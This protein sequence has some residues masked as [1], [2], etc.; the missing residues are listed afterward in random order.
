MYTTILVLDD[1][2]P[3]LFVVS[4][5]SLSIIWHL[6]MNCC[7]AKSSVT[8]GKQVIGLEKK[9]RDRSLTGGRKALCL[10]SDNRSE[11]KIVVKMMFFLVLMLLSL[12][13]L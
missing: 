2:L 9:R 4:N 1:L 5:G 6:M 10:S 12:C 7:R 13:V 11:A 3:D 8:E